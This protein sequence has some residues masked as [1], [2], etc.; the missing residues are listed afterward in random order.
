LF[1]FLEETGSKV[2]DFLWVWTMYSRRLLPELYLTFLHTM[3]HP[4][5]SVAL[6]ASLTSP[7]L[8]DSTLPVPDDEP[9]E[10]FSFTCHKD[11]WSSAD[12]TGHNPVKSV[13][14]HE[15]ILVTVHHGY[16]HLTPLKSRSSASYVSAFSSVVTFFQS[17]SHPFTFLKIDN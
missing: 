15:Y 1:F 7:T 16:I 11:E 17:L 14:G 5:A 2:V 9:Q 8:D 3:H 4:P 12:L 10:S 13:T 6:D